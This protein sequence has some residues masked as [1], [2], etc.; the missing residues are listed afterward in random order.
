MPKIAEM[1]VED[2]ALWCRVELANNKSPVHLW[3]DEELAAK[4]RDIVNGCIEV[5]SWFRN[6]V[7]FT[8]DDVIKRIRDTQ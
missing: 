5:V 8:A 4:E 2:G 6:V 7:Q 3:T 1:K